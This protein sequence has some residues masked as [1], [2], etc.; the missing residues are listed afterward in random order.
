MLIERILL[1]FLALFLICKNFLKKKFITF[2]NLFLRKKSSKTFISKRQAFL[3][4]RMIQKL[5]KIIKI[6][7]CLTKTLAYR[8]A[9]NLAG[10][11]STVYIGVK[12]DESKLF[13]HCW[14][15]SE[16]IFNEK[17]TNHSQFKIIK[18]IL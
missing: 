6:D 15:E 5:S 16:N 9:L 13:S 10:C 3:V 4:I 17:T 11:P 1:I 14:I 18:K 8:N 12:D 2:E 7:S